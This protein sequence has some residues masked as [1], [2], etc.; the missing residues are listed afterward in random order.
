MVGGDAV[1]THQVLVPLMMYVH[2]LG[3][4]TALVS[5]PPGLLPWLGSVRPKHP[6]SSPAAA[7]QTTSM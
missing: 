6:I 1:H 3:L 7:E 2:E 5:M 4:Y